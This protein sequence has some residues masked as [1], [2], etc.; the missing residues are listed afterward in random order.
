[1]KQKTIRFYEN[2]PED[3]SALE[4]LNN[5]RKYGFRSSQE[6]VIEAVNQFEPGDHHDSR[7]L[8]GRDIEDLANRL[9]DKLKEKKIVVTKGD[10]Q[11]GEQRDE[12]HSESSKN[13]TF[14]KALAFME[15]L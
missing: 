2:I 5:Y 6:M 14:Q 10:A 15:S 13:E 12:N 3:I 9:I 8:D 4:K 1:M 7:G 11:Q